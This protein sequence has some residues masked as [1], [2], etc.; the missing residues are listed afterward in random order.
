MI[1]GLDF[2]NQKRRE[3]YLR[4]LKQFLIKEKN[5]L[6]E[7]VK[8]ST[9]RLKD[10]P[11]GSLRLSKTKKYI[12]YYHCTDEILAGLGQMYVADE[13]FRNNIDKHGA[14]TAAFIREAIDNFCRQ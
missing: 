9:K 7:I 2:K 4:G 3:I 1:Y 5:R 12:Q 10:V 11:E 13:R 8:I 6:E 14:G